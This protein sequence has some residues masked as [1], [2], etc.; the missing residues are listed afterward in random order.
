MTKASRY[1]PLFGLV[2][3]GFVVAAFVVIGETPDTKD[4]AA[5]VAAFYRENDSDVSA[6]GVLLMA[7]A[8][9]FLVWAIQMRGLL[10]SA[11]GGSAA[12]TT[13]GLV[14]SVFFGAGMTVFAGLN[15][16]LGDVPERMTPSAIQTLNVLSEDMFPMMAVGVLLVLFGY[17]LAILATHA[18]PAWL[19]W[20]AVA[21]GVAV[22]TP[23]WFAP[24]IVLG[25]VIAVSSVLMVAHHSEA[26]VGVPPAAAPTG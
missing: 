20:L 8:A 18:L 10:Y 21:G 25:L 2:A 11:E 4:S 24:F 6:A 14:G 3:I 12:R 9:A 15:F 1:L 13:F 5:K 17:G 16:A 23:A 19:G 26:T 22:F 7:A